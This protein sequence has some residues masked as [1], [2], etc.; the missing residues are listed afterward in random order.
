MVKKYKV[1][2]LGD[3]KEYVAPDSDGERCQSPSTLGFPREAVLFTVY[4]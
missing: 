4:V 1:L 2:S 3:D